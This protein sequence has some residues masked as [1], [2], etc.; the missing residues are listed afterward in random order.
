MITRKSVQSRTRRFV[1][2][3]SVATAASAAVL[4]SW[5]GPASADNPPQLACGNTQLG[6][7]SE[8]AHFTSS[9]GFS[10]PPPAAGGT[11]CP[12]YLLSDISFMDFAGHGVEHI[13]V[14]K[15]QDA[16]FTSTFTGTGTFTEYPA[17]SL[18]NI[19]VDDQGNLSA[20][21]VGPPDAIVTGH[22]TEW[23]GGSFNNKT[24]VFT[25]TITFTGTDQNGVSIHLHAVDH[26]SWNATSTPFV[27]PPTLNFSKNHITC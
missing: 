7:C 18:A 27:D 3:I 20:D 8:T 4:L 9:Q 10:T 1:R 6:P 5:A 2:V 11:N 17:T 16:W 21:I 15:A 24:V 23:F 19:V 14:N 13:T 12:A 22:L 26:T 25:D